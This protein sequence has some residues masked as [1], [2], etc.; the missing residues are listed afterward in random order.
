MDGPP[1]PTITDGMRRQAWGRASILLLA[2]VLLQAGCKLV[3]QTTFGAKPVPPAPDLLTEALAEGSRIPLVVIH[4]GGAA[5]VYDDTLNTEVDAALAR[6][7]DATFDVVTEVPATGNPDDQTA[8]IERGQ[9]DA[10]GVMSK[11]ADDGVDPARIHLSARTDP[12]I[13][14]RE[15]RL[16]VH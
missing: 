14:A 8:A 6:K 2:T 11:L 3:D 12:G 5:F 16:Y 15:I 4:Y 10:V 13:T 1:S 7:P 9:Q